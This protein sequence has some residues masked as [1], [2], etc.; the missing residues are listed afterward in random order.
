MKTSVLKLVCLLV[1]LAAVLALMPL[2]SIA[3]QTVDDHRVSFLIFNRPEGDKTYELTLTIPQTL[4]QYYTQKSHYVFS[5]RDFSKFVTPQAFQRVADTLWQ[6]YDNPEDFTNAVLTIV[7]QITY[8]ET[9]P[10]F[11]PVETLVRGKGDCDLF[12]YI[13]ASILEAGGI[14]TVLIFYEEQAHMQLGVDL[15]HPPAD[16]RVEA[17]YV[18]YQNVYYYIAECTGS[19]WRTGWRVGECSTTYQNVSFQVSPLIGMEKTSIGQISANLRELDSSTINLQVSPSFMLESTELTISG[20]ILPITPN[21]NVTIR[22]QIPNQ[23]WVTVATIL[24]Q[25]DGR[26]NCTWTPLSVGPIDLQA[27]W[28]GNS[29][30]NGASSNSYNIVILPLYFVALLIVAAVAVFMFAVLFIKLR[31]RR[32]QLPPEVSEPESQI[33]TNPEIPQETPDAMP[34]SFE[35]TANS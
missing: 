23:G 14:N 15:G 32:P 22:A 4:Y 28:I 3:G 17:C 12:V 21:E 35:N 8:E 31:H 29:Q 26:F 9:I 7:H 6:L 1:V 24:T 13:A 10:S 19:A 16:A 2:D 34:E 11:Y 18:D 27:S 30:Y 5:S 25:Q 20:Q 33:I